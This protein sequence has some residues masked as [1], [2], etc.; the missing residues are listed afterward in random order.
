MIEKFEKD[1]R[2]NRL[3]S[4][5]V[6]N[7]AKFWERYRPKV[8]R[9]LQD[10]YCSQTAMVRFSYVVFLNLFKIVYINYLIHIVLLDHYA[11]YS[12]KKR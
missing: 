1:D 4:Q 9:A 11:K 2:H 6:P 3:A 12:G 10:P 5:Q 8:W 7:T